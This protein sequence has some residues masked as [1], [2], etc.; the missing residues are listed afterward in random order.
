VVLCWVAGVSGTG[1]S[2]IVR[3][4]QRLG[5]LAWDAD[6]ISVWR[7]RASGQ[8]ID[9]PPVPLPDGWVATHA[10]VIRPDEV[11][12]LHARA[13]GRTAF[14]AGGS[15]NEADVWDLFETVV[16]L[17]TD[18][19]TLAARLR[20]RTGNEFGKSAEEL[21]MV[22]GWNAVL[23]H[24]YRAAGATIVDAGRPLAD[25]VEAVRAA[26]APRRL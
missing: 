10:W 22:L 24:H 17:V 20:S 23:E 21:A 26:A 3:E 2:T 7:N 1:K 25:V 9:P 8:D 18:D 13:A 14:L 12:E 11:R 15:E 4:L 16:Y 5:E 19:D 6:D